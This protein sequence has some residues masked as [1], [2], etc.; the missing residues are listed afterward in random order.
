MPNQPPKIFLIAAAVLIAGCSTPRAV[1]RPGPYNGFEPRERDPKLVE[2][3]RAAGLEREFRRDRDAAARTLADRSTDSPA[4]RLALARVLLHAGVRLDRRG[5]EPMAAGRYLE[6]ARES[7]AVLHDPRGRADREHALTLYSTASRAFLRLWADQPPGTPPREEWV[8]EGI[9]GAHRVAR[10]SL[11][12]HEWPRDRISELTPTDTVRRRRLEPRVDIEGIGLPMVGS[13]LRRPG[14]LAPRRNDVAV[15]ALL[16][17]AEAPGKPDRVALLDP[18]RAESIPFAGGELPVAADFTTPLDRELLLHRGIRMMEIMGVLNPAKFMQKEGIYVLDPFDPTRIPVVFIHGLQSS[19]FA[20]LP[21]INGLTADAEIRKRCQFWVYQYPSGLPI[22]VAS[23]RVRDHLDQVMDLY[24]KAGRADNGERM[25]LVG[26]SMGGLHSRMQIIDSGNAFFSTFSKI[27]LEDLPLSETTRES[28]RKSLI[29]E[30]RPYVSRAV[31]IATPHKGSAIASGWIGRATISLIRAP[32]DILGMTTE[33][34]TLRD[35]IPGILIRR[36]P[37]SIAGL[38]PDSGFVRALNER[39]LP[40]DVP[41][42]S[43]IGDRGRGNTPD[44]SDGVVP[45]WSSHLKSATSEKIVPSDHG[46]LR[47]PDGIAETRRIL[48]EHL[49]EADAPA[50]PRRAR[51][52]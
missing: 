14:E 46:A 23:G 50:A 24:R 11:P 51:A 38:N 34:L 45:Y 8:V 31:F 43:I 18:K 42:H 12:L 10:A 16:D 35:G 4:D 1:T 3:L 52:R 13:I 27:P 20:W 32:G 19:S 44:S 30:R 21:M 17:P 33:L 9:G 49:A 36:P 26:H 7:A 41:V 25:V 37:T 28:I 15:T 48:L 29:F 22:P 6:S 47:H 39:P 5:A 40:K 2:T